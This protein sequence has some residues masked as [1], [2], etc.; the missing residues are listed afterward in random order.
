MTPDITLVEVMNRYSKH[1]KL[2]IPTPVPVSPIAHRATPQNLPHRL[3]HKVS[4]ETIAQLI[5]DYESGT[6]S[7]QLTRIYGLGKGSV[8]KLLRESGIQMRHHGL[9]R[10]NLEEAASL[11]KDAWS[12]P[13]V[14][15]RFGCRVGSVRKAFRSAG[16]QI[17]PP[18]G[19][20]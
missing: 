15:E 18:N 20:D 6:P 13:R 10:E 3:D 11:Y 12:L 4:P 14:A 16:I 1:P 8:L 5:A 17:G 9:S 7:T 2:V 19:W